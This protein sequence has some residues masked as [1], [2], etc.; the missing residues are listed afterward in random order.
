MLFF[1]HHFSFDCFMIVFTCFSPHIVWNIYFHM[2]NKAKK[3][4]KM[5]SNWE[6][7]VWVTWRIIVP[8]TTDPS[9]I[10]LVIYPHTA[11]NLSVLT[12]SQWDTMV[13]ATPHWIIWLCYHTFHILLFCF[14][15]FNAWIRWWSGQYKPV[16]N[17]CSS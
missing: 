5:M 10:I 11:F 16:L 7:A 4:C 2:K 1:L 8:S 9:L 6:L 14:F 17:T 3:G 12:C 13:Q 15:L